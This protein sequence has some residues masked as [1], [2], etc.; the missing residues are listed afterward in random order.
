MSSWEGSGSRAGIEIC[1]SCVYLGHSRP[2]E[3]GSRECIAFSS[4]VVSLPGRPTSLLPSHGR[5]R[6]RRLKSC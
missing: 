5:L 4:E 2:I 1:A 6:L 3:H